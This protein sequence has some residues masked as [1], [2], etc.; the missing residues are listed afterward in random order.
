VSRLT[1]ALDIAGA[2]LLTG[3]ACAAFGLAA[4]MAVLG[5]FL[6]GLSYVL[7]RGGR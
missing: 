2:A 1:T 4:G 6:L 7:T 5:G 3:A